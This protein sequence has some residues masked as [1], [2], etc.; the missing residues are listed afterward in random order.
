LIKF[1][2]KLNLISI[3]DVSCDKNDFLTFNKV[4]R[5]YSAA[6]HENLLVEISQNKAI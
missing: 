6:D 2:E 1:L 3:D 5:K 4:S